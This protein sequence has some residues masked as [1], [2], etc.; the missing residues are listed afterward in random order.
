MPQPCMWRGTAPGHGCVDG[1]TEPVEVKVAESVVRSWQVVLRGLHEQLP[2]TGVVC[3][4][5]DAVCVHKAESEH[6]H[7][8]AGGGGGLEGTYGTAHIRIHADAHQ[9]PQRNSCH[10]FGVTPV[11]KLV[12]QVHLVS[13]AEDQLCV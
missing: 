9:L 7:G 3:V 12:L 6:A 10:C 11:S 8:V 4:D 5:S 2:C 13:I 1:H